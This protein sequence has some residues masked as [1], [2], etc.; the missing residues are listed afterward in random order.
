MGGVFHCQV[1]G[2]CVCVVLFFKKGFFLQSPKLV[3]R[4]RVGERWKCGEKNKRGLVFA[5]TPSH[6]SQ[7]GGDP[8]R[9]LTGCVKVRSTE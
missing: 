8:Q 2:L 1:V 4:I 7:K 3:A 9:D 5:M 6:L